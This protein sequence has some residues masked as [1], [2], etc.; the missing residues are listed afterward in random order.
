MGL[1]TAK[2]TVT[3]RD[4]TATFDKTVRAATP[5][6]P[7][8]STVVPST[9]LDEK[10]GWLGD[11]PGMREWLGDRVFHELRAANYTIENKHWESSLNIKKTDLADDRHGLY[12]PLLM[13]LANEATYH[14]DELFFT[15]LAA[16]ETSLCFDGQAFFDTDHAWGDSGSQS[17]DLTFNASDHDAVTVAEFKAA[18]QAATEAMIQFVNDRGKPFMRPTVD[19]LRNLLVLVPPELRVVALESVASL[20]LS[21]STNVVVDRPRV[22]TSPHLTS[23]VKMYV[24]NLDPT[25]AIKPFIF[26]A[27]EPLSRQTKGLTDVEFKDVKFMTEA[28]YN[29]GFGLWASAVLTT[30]N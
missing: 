15:L 10:Y 21:G 27:R 3:L 25:Q 30:F 1:D 23:G 8:I 4:L 22:V 6:Y 26:Q 16:A 7:Q 11:M 12:G 18:F 24:F 2:A 19:E 28:R 20:E 13:N 14:P 29:M 17:N 9:G 5:F